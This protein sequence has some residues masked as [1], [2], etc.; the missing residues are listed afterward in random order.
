M[1][2]IAGII[3]GAVAGFL[4]NYFFCDDEAPEAEEPVEVAEPE[5][6]VEPEVVAEPDPE[7]PE[8]DETGIA[9]EVSE[10]AEAITTEVEIEPAQGTDD[11][12]DE[13]TTA[14][15]VTGE[16]V[17][18]AALDEPREG[19]ADDLKVIEGIGPKLEATL[20]MNG[21]YHYDQ[22]AAWTDE[23]VVWMDNNL[24]R[25][26]GRVTRDNWVEQAKLVLKLGVAGFRA[27]AKT[28]D[29]EGQ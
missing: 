1:A 28:N 27:R 5:V 17:R 10:A 29:V 8:S 15:E 7:L 25:F 11:G 16:G 21:I 13:G 24:P 20:N 26:K 3:V 18:P 12:E 19:D 2:I 23:E 22:I 9:P 14:D 6:V 4:L